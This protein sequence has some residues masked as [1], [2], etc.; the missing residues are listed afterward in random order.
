MKDEE[1]G[2]FGYDN[3]SLLVLLLFGYYKCQFVKYTTFE[4][5]NYISR[6]FR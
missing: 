4:K 6:N 1:K 5:H 2:C 3:L